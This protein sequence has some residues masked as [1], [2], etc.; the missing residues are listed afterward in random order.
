MKDM[1]AMEANPIEPA[2]H[3][4]LISSARP[5][6]SHGARPKP[7]DGI[8]LDH[9]CT[10]LVSMEATP[11]ESLISVVTFPMQGRRQVL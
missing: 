6:H 1:V 10:N 7:M 5:R 8:Q 9:M 4:A 3:K 2:L 11:S